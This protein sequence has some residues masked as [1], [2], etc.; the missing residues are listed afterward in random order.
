MQSIKCLNIYFFLFCVPLMMGF[1][2]T[3]GSLLRDSWFVRSTEW[4][5]QSCM[6]RH[7]AKVAIMGACLFVEIAIA[8]Y[9]GILMSCNKGHSD[10]F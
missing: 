4:H 5:A 7:C 8:D 2:F 10:V 6:N 1:F 3:F 9:L